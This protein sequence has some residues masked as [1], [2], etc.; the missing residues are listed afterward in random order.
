[1]VN[2]TP[3]YSREEFARRGPEIFD[4]TVRPTLR[5]DHEGQFVAIDIESGGYEIDPDDY[6]ATERLLRRYPDAQNLAG[7]S[8]TAGRLPPGA[9]PTAGTAE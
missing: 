6:T 1:M 8:R 7:A 5:P 2:H 3:R 9:R 4:R